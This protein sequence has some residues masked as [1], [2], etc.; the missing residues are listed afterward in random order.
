MAQASASDDPH[1]YMWEHGSHDTM[2]WGW[3]TWIK[4]PVLNVQVRI[5]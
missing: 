3:F 1:F 4:T 2:I 5:E